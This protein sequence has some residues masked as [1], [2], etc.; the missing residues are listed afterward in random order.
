VLFAV[1]VWA[2]ARWAFG[3]HHPDR[4][5]SLLGRLR[6]SSRVR[7]TPYRYGATWC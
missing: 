5:T 1:L 4:R 2:L 6:P 3:V 7:R